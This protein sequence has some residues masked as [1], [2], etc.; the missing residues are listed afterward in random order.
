MEHLAG[1][2]EGVEI[3]SI[4]G[5]SYWVGR[6]A[7]KVESIPDEKEVNMLQIR[8]KDLESFLKEKSGYS[9]VETDL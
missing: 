6:L 8:M 4:V 9:P 1:L 5:V 2:L 3:C 7:H